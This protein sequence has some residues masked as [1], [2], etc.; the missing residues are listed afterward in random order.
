MN[1]ALPPQ[2]A[3]PRATLSML[4]YPV[5]LISASSETPEIEAFPWSSRSEQVSQLMLLQGLSC[6]SMM[7]AWKVWDCP[8]S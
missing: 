2:R 5:L 1:A 4:P 6:R 8:S 3:L 7:M